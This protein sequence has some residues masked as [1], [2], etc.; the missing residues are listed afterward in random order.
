MYEWFGYEWIIKSEAGDGAEGVAGVPAYILKGVEEFGDEG[1]GVELLVVGEAEDVGLGL[2][3]D[4][5]IDVDGVGDVVVD[6]TVTLP[7]DDVRVLVGLLLTQHHVLEGSEGLSDFLD[8]VASL[9]LSA[10]VLPL[11]GEGVILAS[12]LDLV[13]RPLLVLLQEDFLDVG[14][15]HLEL[16]WELG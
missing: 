6:E 8:V 4:V 12:L 16:E 9:V 14:Q 2:A 11:V 3:V 7:V 1:P 5:I 10:A 13:L 15:L